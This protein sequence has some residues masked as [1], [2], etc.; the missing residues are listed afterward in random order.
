MGIRGAQCR[1]QRTHQSCDDAPL[2]PPA[3]DVK[4]ETVLTSSPPPADDVKIETVLTS[5][6]RRPGGGRACSSRRWGREPRRGG[7]VGLFQRQEGIRG[8]RGAGPVRIILAVIDQLGNSHLLIQ[9]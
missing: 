6:R 4:I 5:S 2:L 3:D 7:E 1:E 8:G 9:R